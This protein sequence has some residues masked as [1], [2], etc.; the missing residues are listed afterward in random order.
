M[1]FLRQGQ[2]QVLWTLTKKI[3][4]NHRALNLDQSVNGVRCTQGKKM[5]KMIGAVWP[6]MAV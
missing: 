1:V 6:D 2:E 3:L 5:R 4:R